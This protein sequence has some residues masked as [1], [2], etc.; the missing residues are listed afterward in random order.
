M[1]RNRRLS[2]MPFSPADYFHSAYNT[3]TY[4]PPVTQTYTTTTTTTTYPPNVYNPAAIPTATVAGGYPTATTAI[5]TATVAG[6]YPAATTAIPTAT[7]AI[8]TASIAIPT[9]TVPN[10]GASAS[11]NAPLLDPSYYPKNSIV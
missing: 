4:N 3:A 2:S 7:T 5:P 10:T 11:V 6:G 9:T 8:P 1:P